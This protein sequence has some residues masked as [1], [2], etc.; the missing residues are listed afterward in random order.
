MFWEIF[1]ISTGCTQKNHIFW[2]GTFY[3]FLIGI[4]FALKLGI[5]LLSLNEK[6]SYEEKVAQVAHEENFGEIWLVKAP[7]LIFSLTAKTNLKH[8]Y[9]WKICSIK[10]KSI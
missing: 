3:K 2:P 6:K 8:I 10:K 7:K 1:A 5:E 9:C 4:K